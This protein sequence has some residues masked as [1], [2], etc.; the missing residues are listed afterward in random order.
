M[1]VSEDRCRPHNEDHD[2]V[3]M[4]SVYC[5]LNKSISRI[6]HP[7][8]HAVIPFLPHGDNVHRTVYRLKM[9]A[10][11]DRFP[12]LTTLP[13]PFRR[14]YRASSSH[15][16]TLDEYKPRVSTFF[17]RK[18][19]SVRSA[20]LD[21]LFGCLTRV[22]PCAPAKSLPKTFH[23]STQTFSKRKTRST[24]GMVLSNKVLLK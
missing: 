7:Y 20:W 16:M 6:L 5:V 9:I 2:P 3:D 21:D 1:S 11:V 8:R 13:S 12:D 23:S 22:G 17:E 4:I 24:E 14:P 19:E 15:W 18:N 10:Y